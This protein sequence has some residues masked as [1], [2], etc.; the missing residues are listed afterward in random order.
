METFSFFWLWFRCAYDSVYDSDFW[1]S[2]GH[3][4]SYYSAYDSDSDS[5]SVTSEN[6]PQKSFSSR[7]WELARAPDWS[8]LKENLLQ[9]I[10]STTHIWAVTQLTPVWN[11]CRVCSSL[12]SFRR[13]TSGDITKCYDCF[14][15]LYKLKL[16][17]SC[18]N[19]VGLVSQPCLSVLLFLKFILQIKTASKWVPCDC[20]TALPSGNWKR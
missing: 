10:K 7:P 4:P 6:Q 3:K 16:L 13:E 11:F 1:F 18:F 2:L 9:P 20:C 14:L 12:T 8:C 17:L 5:D 19:V 15:R